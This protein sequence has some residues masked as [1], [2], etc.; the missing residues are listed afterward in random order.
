MTR[1]RP[2]GKLGQQGLG[3]RI[4]GLGFRAEVEDL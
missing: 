4:Y 3:F 2:G 1:V